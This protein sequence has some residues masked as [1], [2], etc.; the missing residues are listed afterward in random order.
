[1]EPGKEYSEE[2]T[3]CALA[4]W[5]GEMEMVHTCVCVCVCACVCVFECVCVC[6]CVCVC[7]IVTTVDKCKL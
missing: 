6:V 1:M 3:L 4:T 7:S 2:M 5:S